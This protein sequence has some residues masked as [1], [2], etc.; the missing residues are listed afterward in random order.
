MVV[1]E[2]VSGT[3]SGAKNVTKPSYSFGYSWEGCDRG[4]TDWRTIK[5]GCVVCD[6]DNEKVEEKKL[7]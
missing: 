5:V 6:V 2:K 3:A 7:K 1:V 4:D